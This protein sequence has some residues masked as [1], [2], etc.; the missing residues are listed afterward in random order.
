MFEKP[1]VTLIKFEL[2][3]ILAVSGETPSASETEPVCT[4][5]CTNNVGCTYDIGVY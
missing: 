5:D 2:E 1:T 3:D 4:V